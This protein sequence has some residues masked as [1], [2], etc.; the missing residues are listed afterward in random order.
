MRYD[1]V[2][3]DWNGTIIDDAKASMDS[4]NLML[5]RRGLPPI[6]INI[7]RDY[8]DIPIVK[9]YEKAF[10]MS[11]E[12]MDSIAA[13]FNAGY[14][15]SIPEEPL[16]EGAKEVL[17]A[18]CA[19]GAR[20]FIFS[21]SANGIICSF[22]EKHGIAHYFDAVLGSGDYYVGSKLERTRDYI[23]N[24]GID[25]ERTVFVGDMEHDREVAYACGGD[26]VLLSG[27]HRPESA[28]RAAGS[29][30]VGTLYEF[31]N[32]INFCT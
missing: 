26:C 27:G 16:R 18:L 1:F 17:G 31:F 4:V 23:K 6:D 20:Q 9:F 7:Y 10:D 11:K 29:K 22:L 2:F 19:L 28:L 15:A 13:E 24:H 3:W 25:P 12:D 5:A 21:S 8:V 32:Y 14:N 30:V